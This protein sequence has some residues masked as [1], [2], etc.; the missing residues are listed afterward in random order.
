MDHFSRL[1]PECLQIILQHLVNDNCGATLAALLQTNRYI[2]TIAVSFMYLDPYR[3]SSHIKSEN[4]YRSWTREEKLINCL[5]TRTLMAALLRSTTVLPKVLLLGLMPADATTITPL[6]P[7]HPNLIPLTSTPLLDTPAIISNTFSLDYLAQIR[8]LHIHTWATGV[9]QLWKWKQPPIDV[10]SFIL[11]DK[12][13]DLCYGANLIPHHG[14]NRSFEWRPYLEFYQRCYQVLF[15]RESSWHLA[16]PILEQLQSLTIPLSTIG[17]YFETSSIPRLGRLENVHFTMD[18]VSQKIIYSYGDNEDKEV[19]NMVY[20]REYDPIFLPMVQFVDEHARMF[21]GVLKLVNV[22]HGNLW[23]GISN[24]LRNCPEWILID[25]NRKLPAPETPTIIDT[26]ISLIQ[27]VAHLETTD[28]SKVVYLD[29]TLL[30]S[31]YGKRI[32]RESQH[33]L[34]R[35]RALRILTIAPEVKDVFK[36]ALIEK[37]LSDRHESMLGAADVI[38]SKHDTSKSDTDEKA[39]YQ[40]V[41]FWRKGLIALEEI[42][43]TG[44]YDVLVNDIKIIGTVFNQTLKELDIEI[45]YTPSLAQHIF[46]PIG[47][48]W[49]ILP[50]LTSLSISRSMEKLHIFQD[51]FNRCPSLFYVSFSDDTWSYECHEIEPFSSATLSQ[52][53]SLFLE[54]WPALSF[55][56]VILHSTLDIMDLSI[57]CI[58]Q[59]DDDDMYSYNGEEDEDLSSPNCFIPPI[60]ELDRSYGILDHSIPPTLSVPT[61]IRPDWTWDWDLPKLVSIKL[62]AEFA[63]QFKFCMLQKCPSLQTLDLNIRTPLCT[64]RR[65]ITNADLITCL[66]DQIIAPSVV[67]LRLNGPWIFSDLSVAFQFLAG[68]FPN[69]NT[70]WAL[71]CSLSLNELGRLLRMLPN[72]ISELYLN[73]SMPT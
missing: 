49:A 55:N 20:Q 51:I 61:I 15:Y 24:Y 57:I 46:S 16:E 9:H 17:R 60:E 11:T 28:L 62:N 40:Q 43:L 63:F 59:S 53:E 4:Q 68:M 29:L 26:Y 2:S 3:F 47:E 13:E 54:G 52:L 45:Q 35:C 65:M 12:F 66:G 70:L 58:T 33:I 23:T 44:G 7:F 31:K 41:D 48:G 22:E 8:H 27:L 50:V 36:W 5:P 6:D 38:Y 30:V 64:H 39:L 34:Q 56:P 14:M 73:M 19:A 1:P 67:K 72:P 32:L 37:Q 25:V 18:I 10:S 71:E 42:N 69:L 21:P